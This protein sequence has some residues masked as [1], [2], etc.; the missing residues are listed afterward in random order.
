MTNEL[1][2]VVIVDDHDLFREGLAA[3]LSRSPLVQVVAE[4][5]T[6][7]EALR[8]TTRHRPNVLLLD[9]ELHGDPARLTIRRVRRSAPDTAI[10]VLTMHRDSVLQRDLLTA[11]A[12]SYLT[13]NVPSADLIR[14]VCDP[15]A[16]GGRQTSLKNAV[17]VDREVSG[18]LSIRECQV[19]RLISHAHSNRSIADQLSIA[20]G[21]VKRHAGS[22]YRKLGARS[23]MEAVASA[24]RLGLLHTG[25]V[26]EYTQ[27][28]RD[29][30]TSLP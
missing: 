3:L 27:V 18:I 23:R 28:T 5:R 22:I 29:V 1:V 19:L 9:V 11:G 14:A 12:N 24:A 16:R 25:I 7:E 21:T 10:I 8:L 2:R 20:E 15:A 26:E 30:P 13:K 6:S 4:G 17:A